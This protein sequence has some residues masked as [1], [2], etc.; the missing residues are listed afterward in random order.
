LRTSPAVSAADVTLLKCDIDIRRSHTA[1]Y[2]RVRQACAAHSA[3][4]LRGE[5]AGGVR[6]SRLQFMVAKSK[7]SRR[8]WRRWP[9]PQHGP[10]TRLPGSV[11]R[12]AQARLRRN[13]DAMSAIAS[14]RSP[15][16]SSRGQTEPVR[17][18]LRHT[19]EGARRM[20]EVS[21]RI[22]GEAGQTVIQ[23]ASADASVSQP[24]L[25]MADQ[26][27]PLSPAPHRA[28]G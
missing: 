8:A 7:E 20:V 18:N 15:P 2:D 25:S 21:T 1:A 13:V 9:R 28:A 23:A 27:G 22:A 24:E 19:P 14:C 10:D 6:M 12:A 17:R 26:T 4:S 3:G 16:E 11:A 5:K